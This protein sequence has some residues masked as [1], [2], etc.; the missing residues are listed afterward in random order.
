MLIGTYVVQVAM[1]KG[2]SLEKAAREITSAAAVSWEELQP[3][4]A[5]GCAQGLIPRELL[6][7]E[8]FTWSFSTL[9]SRLVKLPGS[10]GVDTLVP[11]ADML[12]HSPSVSAFFEYDAGSRSVVLRPDKAYRRGEQVRALLVNSLNPSRS[13]CAKKTLH[14]CCRY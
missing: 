9:L 1:L 3:V 2:S 7:R 5:D 14:L 4:L 10:G 13:T 8:A 12:N 11:W 6:S